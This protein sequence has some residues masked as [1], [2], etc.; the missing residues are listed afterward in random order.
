[1]CN[2][3]LLSAV[4]SSDISTHFF[5]RLMLHTRHALLS[6]VISVAESLPTQPLHP[7]LANPVFLRF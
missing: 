1:M 6:A 7:G 5:I 4:I 2:S 3:N